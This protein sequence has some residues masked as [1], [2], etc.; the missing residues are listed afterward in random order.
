VSEQLKGLIELGWFESLDD[1]CD[2][3]DGDGYVRGDCFED[4]CCCEDPD[5]KHGTITCPVCN[6]V[7]K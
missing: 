2:R 6:G 1:P 5:L 3:C 4:T 7:G